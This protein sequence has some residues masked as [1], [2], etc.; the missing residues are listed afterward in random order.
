MATSTVRNDLI[1]MRAGAVRLTPL[2]KNGVPQIDKAVTTQRKFLTSTGITTTRTSETLP[3]GNG[4]DKDFPTAETFNLAL[5]TQVYEPEFHKMLV[6]DLDVV[7]PKPILHDQAAVLD[8]DAT[9]EFTTGKYPAE[10]NGGTYIEVRDSYGNL[11]TPKSS[12]TTLSESEYYYDSS[13]H[14]LQFNAAMKNA[15]F[16]LVYYIAAPEGT[17]AYESH[18]VLRNREFMI[19]VFGEMQSAETGDV[20]R[21][22]AKMVR[23]TVSGDIPRVTSQKAISNAITYNFASAPVGEGVSAFYQSMSPM[24]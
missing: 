7:S 12:S 22:Y 13:A 4:Q 1:P 2:D 21:Y 20:F 23:A 10:V 8:D 5:V 16:S 19:E 6:D 9:Y 14:T 3:N 11:L 24:V 18:T 17:L 15:T